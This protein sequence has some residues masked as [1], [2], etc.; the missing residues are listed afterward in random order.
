MIY[1]FMGKSSVGKDH[2]VKEILK[3]NI[4]LQIAVSHTTRPIRKNEENGVEYHF[5]SQENFLKKQQNEYFIETRKYDTYDVKGNK[6]TWYYGLSYNAIQGNKD[7]IVILDLQ[8]LQELITA[9]GEND[10]EVIY[11]MAD[12]QIRYQRALNRE[13]KMTK[14]Q[15]KEVERRFIADDKDFPNKILEKLDM[16]TLS[17]NNLGELKSNIQFINKIIQNNKGDI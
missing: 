9:I 16:Y 15:I 14:D 2:I 13:G 8:G 3:N 5:I 12:K 10:I 17:N 4:N 11:V 1:V 6:D 7:Y